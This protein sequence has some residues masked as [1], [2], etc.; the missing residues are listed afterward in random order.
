MPFYLRESDVLPQVAGLQ[1]V[2]IVPCR[3][4][5]AASLSV[6]ERKPYIEL[7]R[8]FLRTEAY[9]SFVGALKRRLEDEGIRTAV[10]DS[11]LPHQ[12]VACMWTSRRRRELA[13]RAAEFDGALVLGCDAMVEAVRDSIESTECRVIQGMEIEGLMNVLPKVSFPFNLSLELQGVTAVKS[14]E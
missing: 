3:F 5:P 14:V 6:R 7:F 4:C 10:F 9:E 13:E 12:F 8:R 1:S 11:K 2:L